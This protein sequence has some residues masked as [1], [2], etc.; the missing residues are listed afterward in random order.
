M[1]ERLRNFRESAN[2]L[3]DRLHTGDITNQTDLN[4]VEAAEHVYHKWLRKANDDLACR[5]S[6]V[7][8]PQQRSHGTNDVFATGHRRGNRAVRPEAP[9]TKLCSSTETMVEKPCSRPETTSEVFRSLSETIIPSREQL[10]Q[11]ACGDLREQLELT[12]PQYRP[13]EWMCEFKMS[14]RTTKILN[15]LFTGAEQHWIW[16]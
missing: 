15:L 8:V 10:E 13:G 16:V 11:V 4:V 5:H 9:S 3:A 14:Q 6:R 7:K 12:V 2:A 1:A